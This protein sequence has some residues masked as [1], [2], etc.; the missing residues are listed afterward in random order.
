MCE[1]NKDDVFNQIKQEVLKYMKEEKDK[2][3]SAEIGHVHIFIYN[4]K[5]TWQ[6][7]KFTQGHGKVGLE[8]E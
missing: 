5:I 4:G 2:F 6:A 7:K 3:H 8:N 1:E